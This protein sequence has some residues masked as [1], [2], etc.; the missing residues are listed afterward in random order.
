MTTQVY[1]VT[2]AALGVLTVPVGAL[3]FADAARGA[4]NFAARAGT[5]SGT[6]AGGPAAS[7]VPAPRVERGEAPRD[8]SG[9]GRRF[10]EASF[11]RR[12]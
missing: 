3:M 12:R 8:V 11:P 10:E 7:A 4:E 6:G 1:F 2:S 5:A 9:S